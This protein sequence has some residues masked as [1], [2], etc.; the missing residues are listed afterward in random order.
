MSSSVIK[1]RAKAQVSS[2]GKG[3]TVGESNSVTVHYIRGGPD[4]T[5]EGLWCF[6][7]PQTLFFSLLTRN[8]PF[9]SSQAKEQANYSPYYN[10]IFLPVL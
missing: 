8:K 9:F 10:P 6:S 3:F 4:N 1:M 5:W 7:L 2:L